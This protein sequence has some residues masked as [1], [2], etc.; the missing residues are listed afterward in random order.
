MTD[1]LAVSIFLPSEE[2]LSD[3]AVS[4]GSLS[5]RELGLDDLVVTRLVPGAVRMFI[6]KCIFLDLMLSQ[7]LTAEAAH[8]VVVYRLIRNIR[9]H[10]TL[11]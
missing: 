6:G 1:L 7:L 3:V 11:H 2:P 5:R 10:R 4:A 9:N 8:S